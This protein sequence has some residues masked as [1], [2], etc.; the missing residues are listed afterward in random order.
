MKIPPRNPWL[1]KTTLVGTSMLGLLVTMEAAIRLVFTRTELFG[2]I[3]ILGA[4][5]LVVA[6]VRWVLRKLRSLRVEAVADSLDDRTSDQRAVNPASGLLDL[7]GA[8][9][10][11]SRLIGG[12][13]LGMLTFALAIQGVSYIPLLTG[14]LGTLCA[15]DA[16]VVHRRLRSQRYG[17]ST[18][19][20][21][22]L[23]E[24]LDSNPSPPNGKA[25]HGDMFESAARDVKVSNQA[26]A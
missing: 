22:E 5:M 11:Q 3:V 10:M 7:L 9:T 24:W 16:A 2:A 12:A 19:E 13:S 15:L 14:A 21:L 1:K 26:V 25:L 6:N 18:L 17:E 23:A 8:E 4:L 20:L